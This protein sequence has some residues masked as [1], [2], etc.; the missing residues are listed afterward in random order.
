MMGT[1]ASQS[2][3]KRLHI[4][5]VGSVGGQKRKTR[6]SKALCCQTDARCEA[7]A[8]PPAVQQQCCSQ[9]AHAGLPATACSAG[10]HD[11]GQA[12]ARHAACHAGTAQRSAACD[13]ARTLYLD[14]SSGTT[15]S[16][17]ACSRRA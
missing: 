2:Q 5:P 12:A 9:G 15:T 8:Q 1:W 6:G 17:A 3:L 14:T 4:S 11:V 13:H 7:A 10:W 16:L